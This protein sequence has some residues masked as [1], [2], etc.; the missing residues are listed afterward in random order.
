M[1]LIMRGLLMVLCLLPLSVVAQ[2]QLNVVA[3]TSNMGMLARVVGGGAVNVTVLAPPDRD[4]HH[5]QVRPSMMAAIRRADL[6]V[7]VGAELEIG[8]L[9]PAIQGAANP[10]VNIGQPGYFEAARTVQ[11]IDAGRPADRALGDVHPH[12][13]PHIYLDPIRM[14]V[15]A[16]ALAERMAELRPAHAGQFRANA[17]DFSRA[18]DERMPRWMQMAAKSQGVVLYHADGKYATARFNIPILGYIEPLPGLPPT[19][20]HLR[21]LIHK[22]ANQSGSILYAGF[23]P[24]RGPEFLSRHLG[25]PMNQVLHS[26]PLNDLTMEAYFLLIDSWIQATLSE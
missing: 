19:A 26:V 14:S 11:L 7:S 2:S 8:W 16:E 17:A 1:T 13:N 12:G 24:V 15:A 3:T 4:A 10:R 22:L 18:V 6:V 20:T 5:L 9:P 23:H 25:W 21:T